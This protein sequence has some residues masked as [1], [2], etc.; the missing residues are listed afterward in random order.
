MDLKNIQY[1]F[2]LEELGNVSAA[3]KQLYIS[4]STL[5]LF[6][7][8]YE[9]DLGFPIFQRTK[10]GLKLT[11][12]GSQYLDTARQMLALEK[13]MR[14]RLQDDSNTMSGSII[15]ALSSQ[16]APFILPHILPDFCRKYPNVDVEIVEG[17]T[18]ELEFRLQKGDINLGLLIPPIRTK[19]LEIEEIMQEEILLAVPQSMELQEVHCRNGKMPWLDLHTLNDAT[20]ILHD[21]NNRLHDFENNLFQQ[22]RF[23]PYKSLSYRNT[24][25]LAKLASEGM[26]I[27]FIPDTFVEPSYRL[28]YY[29]IGENGCFR[30]LAL[31]YPAL[32]YQSN[33][34]RKF[35]EMLKDTLLERQKLLHEQYNR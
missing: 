26:G 5:S 16:R 8:K 1:M 4:Q 31:A 34:V 25:L 6:L 14:D 24:D 30:P 11:Y 28:N 10:T 23:T 33:A 21:T 35:S 32:G 13:E 29:S 7:K 18:K 27:T 9:E 3:S 12:E 2:K 19:N 17:R 20:F 15:F 22:Q